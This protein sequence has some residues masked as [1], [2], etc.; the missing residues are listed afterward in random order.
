MCSHWCTLTISPIFWNHLKS[1]T[2]PLY[3]IWSL[4]YTIN[5]ISFTKWY[6]ISP[7][8]QKNHPNHPNHQSPSKVR[9]SSAP[10]SPR[11]TTTRCAAPASPSSVWPRDGPPSPSP[12]RHW[13]PRRGIAIG[14]MTLGEM[15]KS[16]GNL[17]IL[18][19]FRWI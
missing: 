12:E 13:S 7:T 3:S 14:C 16:M 1:L 8:F 15:A 19:G 2:R 17:W 6:F 11:S 4:S 18:D 9:C 10:I 5:I